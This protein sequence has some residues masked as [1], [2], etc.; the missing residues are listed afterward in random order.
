MKNLIKYILSFFNLK[1]IK[2]GPNNFIIFE[3]LIYRYYKHHQKLNFIQI[4]ANDGKSNDPINL[5]VKK[6]KK[7]IKG[8]LFEPDP[9]Y[10]KLLLKNYK[11]NENLKIFNLAIHN[12]LNKSKLYKVADPIKNKLPNF[13]RGVGSFD[14]NHLS[15][16][17]YK[18]D[19]KFIKEIEVECINLNH[20]ILEEKIN[21]IDLLIIDTEG[22]D[23]D[24]LNN[25]DFQKI[26]PKI[27]RFEH[28][29]KNNIM[30]TEKLILIQNKLQSHG[31]NF[32]IEKYDVT[33]YLIDYENF[34]F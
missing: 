9:E 21:D 7:N 19:S 22:Y 3:N 20:F 13:L 25:I 8:Y 18:I 33:S 15:K 4:G 28:G 14:K 2:I 10:Y 31:Y 17:S 29:F 26:K 11:N 16:S 6:N 5:F 30:N 1:L 34:Y 12:T 23:F 32:I 27:I 24:I